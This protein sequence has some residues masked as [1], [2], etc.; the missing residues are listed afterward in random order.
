MW[1]RLFENFVSKATD[2]LF[3]TA[4]IEWYLLR[5]A[6]GLIAVIFSP[7]LVE[8]ILNLIS[9]SLPEKY[10][11]ALDSLDAAK[12][13]ILGICAIMIIV[14][15]CIIIAK[16]LDERK[17]GSKKRLIIIE[18]RGLRDDDGSPLVDVIPKE[19]LGQRIPILLDLRNRKDGKVIDP[20]QAISDIEATHHSLSQQKAS[21]DRGDLTIFYGGLTSVPYTFLTGILID[22]EG[23]LVTYDWDRK[24]E[25]WR[26]INGEDDGLQFDIIGADTIIESK[27]VVLALTYSY[28]I[29]DKD[30][31]TT[32]SIP[33]VRMTLNGMSSDSHWSDKKQRRLAQQ[34]L[35]T[36]KKLSSLGVERVHLVMAAPNSVVFNFARRYD[37]RNLPQIVV[38]QYERGQSPAYPWGIEMPVTGVTK[39]T[40][41]STESKN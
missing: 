3:R 32:F 22:D 40:V 11:S 4:K 36:I 39:A 23:A 37:K 18:G 1:R 12:P 19:I 21:L 41:I 28:P 35:E 38:Y 16:F 7:Q 6:L 9:V 20:Y 15:L 5:G 30:L 26:S 14:A 13:F 33:V 17:S 31:V 2:W 34:F 8:I 29:A 27:D 25:A 10:K 24:Q